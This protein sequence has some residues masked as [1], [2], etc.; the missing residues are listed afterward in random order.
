LP[1]LNY[2]DSQS[3]II[4]IWNKWIFYNKNGPMF[5]GRLLAEVFTWTFLEEAG[6]M[7]IGV[8]REI[9]NSE[10]RVAMVPSGVKTLIQAGHQIL[11]QKGA[12]LGSGILDQEYA[13]TGAEIVSTNQDVFNK[14]EMI[15]KVKEP[16]PP[17]YSL[18]REG[19][20][21]FTFLHL[22]PLP[23]LTKALLKAKIVGIAYETI[24]L[25]DRS[26]P[27]LTPM[28]E[29]AGRMSVHVGA[30]LLHKERGGSGVLLGGVPGVEAGKVVI[31][32]GG[33]VGTNAAKMAVG[34]G[35]SVSI[36]DIDLN[37]LRYLD[38]IFGGRAHLVISNYYTIEK[39]VKEAD[40]VIGGVLVTGAKAPKLVTQETVSKMKKG[41]VIVDVAVDQGGC[42]ETCSPTNHE[43]PTFVVDGVV[44]YCVANMPGAVARTSTFALTNAT[45]PYVLK[46]ANLGYKEAMERDPTLMKGLNVHFGKLV[47]K[48]VA[49]SQKVECA[50]IEF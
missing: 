19:Q 42:I 5:S 37:R 23:D 31:L 12:G 10:N 29:I 38:D 4:T 34:T 32:G 1:H 50:A 33:T 44:H 27:L 46:I 7:I 30:S 20:I 15:L 24:Q 2:S 21:L 8:P 39:L 9:K 14:A 35:A 6:I 13:S 16:L 36:L 3:I 25:E 47:C 43:N 45:F 18:L 40:L 41:S 17:E 28:S 26:L 22:A 11:I 49:D 48:P